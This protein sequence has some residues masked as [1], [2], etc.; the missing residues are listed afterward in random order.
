[1]RWFDFGEEAHGILAVGQF[2]T[3][4]VAVGQ[5]SYGLVSIG[6]VAFGG[7]AIGQLAVGCVSIGM[8]G[9]GLNVVLAF[10]GV[11]GR[12][13]GYVVPLLPSLGPRVA[14]AGLARMADLKRTREPGWVE[15]HLEPRPDGRIAVYEDTERLREVRLDARVRRAATAVVPGAVY[16][17]LRPVP[18]G[19]V[20]ER[21]IASPAPRVTD[22]RWWVAWSAQVAGLAL[23]AALVWWSVGEPL[24][25]TWFGPDGILW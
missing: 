6:Q 22:P 23:L 25:A 5:V 12:G 2:A 11:G 3:G 14:P 19:W 10:V 8:A 17:W 13:R 15:L 4:V 21:L 9:A 1:M 18:E 24:L 20:A 16:A 7:I